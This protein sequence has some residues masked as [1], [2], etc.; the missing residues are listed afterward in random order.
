MLQAVQGV[1]G[2]LQGEKGWLSKSAGTR[3]SLSP[4]LLR[5]I[6]HV[7]SLQCESGLFKAICRQHDNGCAPTACAFA[8]SAS[9]L[10]RLFGLADVRKCP[11][12]HG[13]VAG[14]LVSCAVSWAYGAEELCLVAETACKCVPPLGFPVGSFQ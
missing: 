4:F 12:V 3:E 6:L 5:G 8:G 2:G 7:A 1:E 11:V 13:A 9:V 14:A 10:A